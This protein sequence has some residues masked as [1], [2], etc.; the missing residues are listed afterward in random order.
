FQ[1][2]RQIL[3]NHSS[4]MTTFTHP[5][6][7]HLFPSSNYPLQLGRMFQAL[8]VSVS[9]TQNVHDTN[10]STQ[11]EPWNHHSPNPHSITNTISNFLPYPPPALFR[12]QR[13]LRTYNN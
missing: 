9:R 1:E 2:L 4:E 12:S 6:P 8:P 5:N 13:H 7:N 11:T 3:S 10:S